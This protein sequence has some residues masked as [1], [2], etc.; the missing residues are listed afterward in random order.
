[1]SGQ[2]SNAEAILNHEP[3]RGL[4]DIAL[5][6][7]DKVDS[8]AQ[9]IAKRNDLDTMIMPAGHFRGIA[10]RE[11][12][13]R[14]LGEA[15]KGRGIDAVFYAGFMKVASAMFCQNFPGVNIHPSNLTIVDGDG[16]PKYRGMGALSE[17]R[18]DLGYVQSTVHVV[19]EK[20][21]TGAS[22]ALTPEL[23]ISNELSDA[24]AHHA[25]KSLEHTTYPRTLQLIAEG[26]LNAKNVPL[27]F[28][29]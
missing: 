24:Q 15:L 5:I 27:R 20:V 4:Y 21:D 6:A 12:Y 29:G 1:M 11:A 17:M 7:S 10:A 2:G 3:L 14:E 28:E 13:F 8:N 9:D 16:L 22:L 19:E 18:S 23:M 25:L 26:V